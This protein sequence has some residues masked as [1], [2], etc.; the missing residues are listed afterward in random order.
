MATKAYRNEAVGAP[1]NNNVH[2]ESMFHW[3]IVV[4]LLH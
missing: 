3:S 1:V 2:D 4:V